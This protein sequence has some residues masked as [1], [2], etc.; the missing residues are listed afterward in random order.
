MRSTKLKPVSGFVVTKSLNELPKGLMR[1]EVVSVSS[2]EKEFKVGDIVIYTSVYRIVVGA[3]RLISTNKIIAWE[4][5]ES[6]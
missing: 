5:E 2:D 1:A 6:S 3:Y 4:L